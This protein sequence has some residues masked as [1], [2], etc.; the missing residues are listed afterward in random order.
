MA[1]KRFCL[2]SAILV[3]TLS[4][5]LGLESLLAGDKQT[6]G[7]PI[8]CM[9]EEVRKQSK[10]IA[11]LTAETPYINQV[12]ATGDASVD[13]L[14]L[15]F[16]EN[17]DCA[18]REAAEEALIKIGTER[19]LEAVFKCIEKGLCGGQ[20]YVIETFAREENRKYWPRF[21][22]LLNSE[23]SFTRLVTYDLLSCLEDPQYSKILMREL[24]KEGGAERLWLY[25][26]LYEKNSYKVVDRVIADLRSNSSERRMAAIK[27]L[28]IKFTP[29]FESKFHTSKVFFEALK[30]DRYSDKE[31]S[32]IIKL[33]GRIGGPK[34]VKVLL[35]AFKDKRYSNGDKAD[36]VRI[37]GGI[38]KPSIASKIAPFLYDETFLSSPKKYQSMK[39]EKTPLRLCDV[40][41]NAIGKLLNHPYGNFTEETPLE[42]RDV[43]VADWRKWHEG[44]KKLEELPKEVAFDKEYREFLQKEREKYERQG[45]KELCAYNI[46]KLGQ[47]L[48]MYA[49]D[50]NERFPS[51]LQHLYGDYIFSPATFWCPSD[52]DS[53]PLTI[54]NNEID[55]E[56]SARISYQYSSGFGVNDDP[57]LPLI[58]DNGC[59]GSLDNHGNEGGHV[60]YLDGRVEWVPAK[61]WEN[62]VH[63]KD[64]YP[65][66]RKE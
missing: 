65:G 49:I 53:K 18:V 50:Y 40:A 30:D 55:A 44:K 32:K 4:S 31:K 25:L 7:D 22:P 37:L 61:E 20:P 14:I 19:A 42:V 28:S 10:G 35:E 2:R 15:L 16:D 60:F 26:I 11:P 3:V 33:L 62:P 8:T 57:K 1:S 27:F 23:D 64:S 29:G 54:N 39:K 41:V 59:S 45:T 47:A 46:K 63:G 43:K 9:V 48:L 52:K 13:R 6:M 12:I 38:G 36:F 51:T 5:F 21:V 17:E 34:V 66:K 24:E 58:W 56:N